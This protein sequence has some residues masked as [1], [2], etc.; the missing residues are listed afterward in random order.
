MCYIDRRSPPFFSFFFS[1]AN[2]FGM[3]GE[4]REESGIGTLFPFEWVTSLLFSRRANGNAFNKI[5]AR[6]LAGVIYALVECGG[7]G[8]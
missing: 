8:L 4:R 3:D 5:E 2:C 6:N 7:G 1:T